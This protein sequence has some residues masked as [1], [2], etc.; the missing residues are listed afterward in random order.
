MTAGGVVMVA[1]AIKH[2]KLLC[3]PPV[4]LFNHRGIGGQ[5]VVCP[6]FRVSIYSEEE[7]FAFNNY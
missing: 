1:N 3:P 5:L 2:R 6:P 7:V 4:A